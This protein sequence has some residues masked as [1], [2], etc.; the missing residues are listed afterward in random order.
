VYYCRIF[1]SSESERRYIARK[2]DNNHFETIRVIKEDAESKW[3]DIWYWVDIRTSQF[4][5]ISPEDYPEY[6]V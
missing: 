2:V 5:E 1:S 3:V 6:F 4:F